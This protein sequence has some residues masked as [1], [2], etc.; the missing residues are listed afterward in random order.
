M[1]IRWT[2][3]AITLVVVLGSMSGTLGCKKLLRRKAADAGTTSATAAGSSALP[4]AS[5]QDQADEALQEKIDPYIVCL[6]TVSSPVR[7]TRLQYFSWVNP[8]TGPTGKERFVRGL[9]S[10]P[11]SLVETCTK[12]L[13]KAKTLSPRDGSAAALES[14][15]DEYGRAATEL[16]GL[17]DEAFTYYDNKN[18][19][20][21]KFAKGKALHPKLMTAF[22]AFSKADGGLHRKLD[23]ITR[24][25][26]R[27]VLARIEREDGKQ[28]RYHRKH[29]LNT[30]RELVEAGDPGGDDDSVDFAHYNAAFSDFDTALNELQ[31][32]GESN[33]SKLDLKTTPS[34]PSARLNYEQ[35]ARSSDEYR[36]KAREFLRCLRDAPAKARLPSGGVDTDKM[37]PCNDGRPRDVV[38]KYN[39]F[40]GI[41]NRHQFP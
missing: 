32:F 40:I 36:K 13:A 17:V 25:L 27:R 5:P 21:D 38:Q 6:N 11:K 30:A 15:G 2:T 28:F 16:S 22:A 39:D 4:Q 20:D 14:A 8:K 12:G 33:K 18:F 7:S 10:L 29:V 1:S 34:W 9:V 31:A 35:F 19:K 41:S 24:P 26:A 3:V 23:E 37:G